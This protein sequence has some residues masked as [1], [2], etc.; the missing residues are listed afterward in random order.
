M[1]ESYENYLKAIYYISKKNRGGWVSN[2]E[3]STFLKVKPSSVSGMLHK[4]KNKDLIKWKPRSSLRLTP[5]GKEIAQIIDNR[6]NLFREFF[7]RGLKLEETSLIDEMCCKIEHH[8]TPEI[9]E[10]LEK[11]NLSLL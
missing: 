7:I 3:I 1:R 9:S 11:L 8:V 10:A 4:L 5:K 2:L 6:Y